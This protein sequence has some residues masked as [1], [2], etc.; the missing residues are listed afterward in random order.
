MSG[1]INRMKLAI[2]IISLLVIA[3]VGVLVYAIVTKQLQYVDKVKD[4][5]DDVVENP[6]EA[7]NTL[8]A[9]LLLPKMLIA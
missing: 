2:I 3:C 8:S 6:E 1:K 7:V 9:I 5:V 4:A